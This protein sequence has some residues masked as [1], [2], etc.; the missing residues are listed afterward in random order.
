MRNA[1]A[2]LRPSGSLRAEGSRQS[3]SAYPDLFAA[4]G[5]VYGASGPSFC[6]PDI[7]GYFPVSKATSGSG[8][9][10]GANGGSLAPTPSLTFGGWTP[11]LPIPGHTFTWSVPAHTQACAHTLDESHRLFEPG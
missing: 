6:L 1:G 11:S 4:I 3:T 7:R 9:G 5:Y 2:H 10:L 8:S